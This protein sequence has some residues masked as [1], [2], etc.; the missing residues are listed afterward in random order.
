MEK[1]FEI[2]DKTGRVI[3]LT[4]ERWKHI[5]SPISPHSYM[6]NYLEEIKETLLNPNR[7]VGSIY[8]DNKVIYYKY[9]KNKEKFLKAIVKYL[10]GTGYVITSYFVKEMN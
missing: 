8:E 6:T 2:K 4:K 9:Y 1:I 5:T 7:I 3:Y 10:N